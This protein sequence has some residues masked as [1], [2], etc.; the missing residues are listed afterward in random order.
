VLLVFN[1]E[2]VAGFWEGMYQT[3]WKDWDS[4]IN[5]KPPRFETIKW[6]DFDDSS[7]PWPREDGVLRYNSKEDFIR[8][9]G[10][11]EHSY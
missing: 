2:S 10:P 3:Q 6:D 4:I 5:S 1:H 9:T 11:A 7:V 8:Y